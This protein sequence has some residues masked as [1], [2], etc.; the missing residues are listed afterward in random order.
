MANTIFSK[1][2]FWPK[3]SFYS[4]LVLSFKKEDVNPQSK[5]SWINDLLKRN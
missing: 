5:F 3:S 1:I 4:F 2:I